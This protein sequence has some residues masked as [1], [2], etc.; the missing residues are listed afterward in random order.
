MENFKLVGQYCHIEGENNQSARY[1]KNQSDKERNHPQN[2]ITLCANCHSI[3]D[4]DPSTYTTEFIH[5]W[6]QEDEKS[7][8]LQDWLDKRLPILQIISAVQKH[9]PIR[10][11]SYLGERSL[12]LGRTSEIAKLTKLITSGVRIV[13]LVGEGG[14]GKTS[15]SIKVVRQIENLFEIIIPISLTKDIK[16]RDFLLE[17]GKFI[18]SPFLNSLGTTDIEALLKEIIGSVGKILLVVDNYENIADFIDVHPNDDLQ[19]IHSFLETLPQDAVIILNSRNRSN[20]EGETS[21]S[22]D[23]LPVEDAIKLFIQMA[24]NYMP[25]KLWPEMRSKIE[26]ICNMVNGHPLAIKLLGGEYRGGGVSRLIEMHDELFSSIENMR[27]PV[28]RLKSIM[29]C[30]NYSF[31]RLSPKLQ[32]VLLQLTLFKSYFTGDSTRVI[33]GIQESVLTDLF[34]RTLLQRS[35]IECK[36]GSEVFVYDFHPVIRNYLVGMWPKDFTF[37]PYEL[38][39]FI[40]FY[41]NFIRTLYDTFSYNISKNSIL[42]E[43]LTEGSTTDLWEAIAGIESEEEKSVISNLLGLLLLHTGYKARALRYHDYVMISILEKKT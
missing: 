31:S 37:T 41:C 43:L 34:Q 28:D 9:L 30:F 29:A 33:L 21:V 22:L 3:I 38:N 1:N 36:D 18:D 25:E 35:P 40:R 8:K 7:S 11:T 13:V 20:L 12:F 2:C 6:K 16:Y 5:K 27:E 4:K 14:V 42:L 10:P 15:V 17:V 26:E 23:G 19:G 39:R 32:K 24:K